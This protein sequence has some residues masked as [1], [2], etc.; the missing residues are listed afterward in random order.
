MGGHADVHIGR[1]TSEFSDILRISGSGVGFYFDHK[2]SHFAIGAVPHINNENG[3]TVEGHISASGGISA[4]GAIYND[5]VEIVDSSGNI[6]N[7]FQLVFDYQGRLSAGDKWYTKSARGGFGQLSTQLSAGSNPSGS[8]VTYLAAAR[9][10]SYTAPRACK[11]NCAQVIL[12][13]YTNDDDVVLGIYKGTAV[14]DSNSNIT[15]SQIGTDI[16][17]SMDED[18]T[19]MYSQNFSS[20]NTLSQGDFILFTI[21]TQGYTS[22]SYPQVN[23]NLELQYT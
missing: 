18:K 4:S 5:T 11:V 15:I 13:N 3:L 16:G 10:S 20:G 21:H 9:Y 19:Y 17:G 6:K 14:N 22:T 1:D 23:I 7:R 8:A 2:H 12:L